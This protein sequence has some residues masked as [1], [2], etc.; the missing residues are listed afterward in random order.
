MASSWLQ[1]ARA[2][3]GNSFCR[4]FAWGWLGRPFKPRAADEELRWRSVKGGG[5]TWRL[6]GL[7]MTSPKDIRFLSGLLDQQL[8]CFGKDIRRTQGNLLC[9][10]GMCRIRPVSG[11][12][13]STLYQA[14]VRGGMVLSLWGFGVLLADTAGNAMWVK[15]YTFDPFLLAAQPAGP[16]HNPRDLGAMRRPVNR[17]DAG[18]A[19]GLVR[20]LASWMA[21]YE[22]WVAENLGA[23]YRQESLLG[24]PTVPVV[25]GREMA[26]TWE[27]ISRR[28]WRRGLSDP[29]V[30]GPWAGV[31]TRLRSVAGP[32]AAVANAGVKEN[33][34]FLRKTRGGGGLWVA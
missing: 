30:P 15:R 34:G 11:G 12:A 18:I 31:L 24:K 33:R 23:G 22:H 19:S 2:W 1:F 8:W 7:S 13:G 32:G 3:T 5:A 26:M 14:R 17:T 4:W 20:D 28:G 16:V 29:R 21:A 6:A 27:R 10:L 9:Q 25:R